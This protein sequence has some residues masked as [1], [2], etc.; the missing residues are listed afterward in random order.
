MKISLKILK[1]NSFN[2]NLT[3]FRAKIS[4]NFPYFLFNYPV[5]FLY[6][7]CDLLRL[8]VF[9]SLFPGSPMLNILI[10]Y[11]YIESL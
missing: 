2:I 6:F 4:Q 8:L 7:N 1:K 5:K 9:L 11:Y 10:G 3:K